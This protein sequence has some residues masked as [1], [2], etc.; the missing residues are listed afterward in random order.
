MWKKPM[1]TFQITTLIS[2][3]HNIE[4][5]PWSKL[6]TRFHHHRWVIEVPA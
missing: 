6:P 4:K 3:T 2:I 1:Y 5:S